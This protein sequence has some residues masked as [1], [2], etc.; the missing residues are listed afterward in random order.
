MRSRSLCQDSQTVP[1]LPIV[2][3][4]ASARRHRV[5]AP[6]GVREDPYY[7]L[8][9]DERQ[10]AEILGH[11]AA[12]TAYAE[13]VLAPYKA[14][15]DELYEE[16]VRRLKQDDSSVPVRYRGNWYAVRYENG[17]EHPIVVR[18]ADPRGGGERPAGLQR[19]G[20]RSAFLP[21]RQLRSESGQPI[22]RLHRR[23]GGPTTIQAAREKIL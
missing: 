13:A 22:A 9:D 12:E 6:H 16:I 23:Y 21:A 7:W 1:N 15:I 10:D 5:A 11:L 18:R 8:R 20:G 14:L 2:P 4:I 3:P 19:A 17:R